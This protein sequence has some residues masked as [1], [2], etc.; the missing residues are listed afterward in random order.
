MRDIW[1]D[2]QDLKSEILSKGFPINYR[3]LRGP[4]GEFQGYEVFVVDRDIFWIAN[5][6]S[7]QDIQDFETNFKSKANKLINPVAEDGKIYV[8]AET[9]PIECTTVF[10]TVGDSASNIGDGKDLA[11]DFST[12]DDIITDGV[13]Q[14]Y[15]RKR[16]EFRFLDDVYIK[17]GAIYFFNALKGSYVDLKVVC[18]A[19]QYYRDNNGIPHLATQDTVVAHYVKKHRIQGDCPMG[20]ELNSE[21][22]SSAIPPNYKFW[23]EVTVPES[24]NL[25]NGWVE[26]ELYR[27]RT[28]IL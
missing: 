28:V 16:I 25:S 20:D 9:R 8:R 23:L 4:L 18:P 27:K 10:T 12:D 3:I 5:A 1:M 19:G 17:D 7:G 2:Y 26:I 24:D 13:P 14:G 15:K 6:V 11:W 22:T 21:T